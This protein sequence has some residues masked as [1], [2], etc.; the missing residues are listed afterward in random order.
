VGDN[1]LLIEVP[2]AAGQGLTFA[3]FRFSS[4]GG[5]SYEGTAPDGEVEDYMLRIF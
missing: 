5:L 3:R 4:K 2:Q 1:L